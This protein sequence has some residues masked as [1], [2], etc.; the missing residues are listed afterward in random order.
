MN[1]T[2]IYFKYYKKLVELGLKPFDISAAYSVW[3]TTKFRSSF[4]THII[5]KVKN[6]SLFNTNHNSNIILFHVQ[7]QNVKKIKSLE[8]NV[9]IKNK[10]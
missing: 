7:H 5:Q 4:H 1:I 9:E 2:G 10:T 3:Y 6:I 8:N